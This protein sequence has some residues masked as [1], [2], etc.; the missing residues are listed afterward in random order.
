MHALALLMLL[1]LG[2]PAW[3]LPAQNEFFERVRRFERDVEGMSSGMSETEQNFHHTPITNEDFGPDM[4]T[5]I[6]ETEKTSHR[7]PT[8][9]EDLGFGI[10]NNVTRVTVQGPNSEAAQTMTQITTTI[11]ATTTKITM[12]AINQP[13]DIVFPP[14]PTSVKIP[15]TTTGY[16]QTSNT[17]PLETTATPPTTEVPPTTVTIPTTTAP[18]TTTSTS[19]T[20]T[21]VRPATTSRSAGCGGT[22]TALSGEITSPN[23]PDPYPRNAYCHWNITATR[24]VIILFL[25]F[26]LEKNYHCSSDYLELDGGLHI[27]SYLPNNKYCGV[28][29]HNTGISFGSPVQVVF[30]SDLSVQT[31]GFR[32]R[33]IAE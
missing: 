33:Y 24:R 3:A 26:E 12:N 14:T 20:T 28:I 16:I 22:L 18:T 27:L 13:T 6:S 11:P 8:T 30:V 31:R 2:A 7:T 19:R 1:G 21:T 32:L 25:D 10:L 9:H 4:S 29:P 15:T 5:G 17:I 23:Y